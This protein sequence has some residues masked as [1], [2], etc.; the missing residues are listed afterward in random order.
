MAKIKQVISI[1]PVTL[2]LIPLLLLFLFT[3][4]DKS[5]D[6]KETKGSITGKVRYGQ[7]AIHPAFIFC[8]DSLWATTDESGSYSITSVDEGSISLLCSAINYRDTTSQVQVSGGQTVTHDFYMTP[9]TSTGYVRGEFQDIILFNDSLLHHPS[10]ANWDA[11]QIWQS[12]TGATL[13]SKFLQYDVPR[14]KIYLD[15][16][17]ISITDDWAQFAFK[18]QSGTY[19]ITGTCDGYYDASETVTVLPGKLADAVYVTFF[20]MRIWTPKLV[21][22]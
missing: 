14:A 11:Q 6:P 7:T 3:S 19:R 8:G 21:M 16:T 15:G 22:K 18:L 12:S 10:M 5:T 13:I 2:Y 9:D 17:Q 4:C 1:Y 20:M